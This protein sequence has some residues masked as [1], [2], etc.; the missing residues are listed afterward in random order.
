MLAAGLTYGVMEYVSL[1]NPL[2]HAFAASFIF[3][4]LSMVLAPLTGAVTRPDIQMIRG[5][6][7]RGF[8]GY[9]LLAPFLDLEERIIQLFQRSTK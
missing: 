7:Q 4:I 5:I 3:L 9:S 1:G 6:I 2:V 8:R